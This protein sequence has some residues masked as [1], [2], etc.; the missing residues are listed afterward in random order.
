MLVVVFVVHCVEMYDDDDCNYFMCALMGSLSL[1]VV[2]GICKNFYFPK[3]V[4]SP[5]PKMTSETFCSL[6]GGESI[7]RRDIG[8]FAFQ[9]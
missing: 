1:D 8:V 4:S 6:L 7:R 9:F 3:R 5:L 2:Q